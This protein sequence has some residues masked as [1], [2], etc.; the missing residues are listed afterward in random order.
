MDSPFIYN[1]PVTG[2]HFTGRKTDI[3]ILG[4]LLRA[5][6]NICIYEPPKTGKASLIN[7]TLLNLKIAGERFNVISVS[8]LNVRT[9]L[10]LAQ[11]TGDAIIRGFATT[12]DEYKTIV[13]QMLPGTH[14]IF[15]RIAFSNEDRI[16]SLNWDL[17]DNDIRSVLSL[18]FR[19][20][21]STGTK[22]F[23]VINEF[24]N[25]MLTEDG[26]KLCHM[27]EGIFTEFVNNDCSYLMCGSQ[28]NAMKE[29]FEHRR[30]FYRQVEHVSLSEID[31]KETA[32]YAVKG[33]LIGGK[34]IDRNIMIGVCKLFRNHQG[35]I[36]HLMAISDSLSK[37]Y[38]TE[39]TLMEALNSLIAIH[40]PRF[41]AMMNDLTTYQVHLLKAIADGNDKFSASEII[42]KYG[43]NSSA[44]VRR[45]KDALC[46]KEIVTFNSR[47]Q[48]TILD[49]L[50]EYWVNKY[51]FEKKGI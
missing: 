45:L 51:Y 42:Q 27:L 20:A 18:P 49:P 3:T 9:E 31:S 37:G 26:E 19:L 5:C 44:N 22:V 8:L 40:E 41:I 21:A 2:K 17:D 29:I 32:E 12:P 34:V 35:Y 24:Q 30:F 13:D 7:Q 38:I 6:E 10:E 48:A 36:N 28:V 11:K 46:K 14:F 50:F 16:L 1:V 47:E 43:L 23:L 33:F 39:A 4:N 15:D 25:I